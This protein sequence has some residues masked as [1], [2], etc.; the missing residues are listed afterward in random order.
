L[1]AGIFPS[2]PLVSARLQRSIDAVHRIAQFWADGARDE[3]LARVGPPFLD[4]LSG[5]PDWLM[6]RPAGRPVP[7]VLESDVPARFVEMRGADELASAHRVAAEAF[8]LTEAEFAPRWSV[9]PPDPLHLRT[10]ALFWESSVLSC[11]LTV[12]VADAMVMC[13]LATQPA[14]QGRGLGSRILR[15]LHHLHERTGVIREF[16]ACP[17]PAAMRTFERLGYD[18]VMH[19]HVA[20]AG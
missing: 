5:R 16:V 12:V 15:E 18:R 4:D 3:S 1:E 8:G 14:L 2:E 19:R 11:A 20:A 10:W 9:L 7:A 6:S 13:A 17:P